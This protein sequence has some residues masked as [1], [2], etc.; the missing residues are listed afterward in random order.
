MRFLRWHAAVERRIRELGV[1]ATF[2][3]PN[4]YFQGLLALAGS[5]RA[6]SRFFAP[7]G[8]ARVSAVDVRD[9]AEVAAAALTKPG[10]EGRTYS[11]TGPAAVTHAEVAVDISRAV[12]REIT[13]SDVPPEMLAAAL[14]GALPEWQVGGLLELRLIRPRRGSA[15]GPL[16]R[17]GYGPAAAALRRVR[18]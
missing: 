14:R 2:L 4:L 17:T 6:E 5:I 1:G 9:I 13:F 10:H 7:I 16:R 3:R 12:G 15:C 11:I 8:D 18:P